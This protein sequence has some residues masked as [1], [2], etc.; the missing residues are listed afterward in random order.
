MISHKNLPPLTLRRALCH[1]LTFE[2]V[3]LVLEAGGMG[4]GGE[5]FV[6]NMGEPVRIPISRM[7][8]FDYQGS[9][10]SRFRSW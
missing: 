7:T 8:V 1:W 3:H 5:L 6:L 9:H 10:R 4:K 2:A